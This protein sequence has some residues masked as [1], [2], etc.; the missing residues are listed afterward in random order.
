MKKL[1]FY[2][3]WLVLISILGMGFIG[4]GGG[5]DNNENNTNKTITGYVID[6]PVAGA[7]IEVYDENGTLLTKEENATDENGKYSITIKKEYSKILL[8]AYGGEINNT[9][10]D[11]ELSSICFDDKCNMTPITT[12]LA[13]NFEKNM[14]VITKKDLTNFSKKYLNVNDYKNKDESLNEKIVK[15]CKDNNKKISTLAI[16]ISKN[17]KDLKNNNFLDLF[18]DKNNFTNHQNNINKENNTSKYEKKTNEKEASYVNDSYYNDYSYVDYGNTN[19]KTNTNTNKTITGYVIDD[20]VVGAT[21]EVYDENGTLLTKEENATD[22]N[23]KFSIPISQNK[24]FSPILKLVAYKNNGNNILSAYVNVDKK[25]K[26]YVTQDTTALIDKLILDNKKVVDG[27]FKLKKQYGFV[28]GKITDLNSYEAKKLKYIATQIEHSFKN[29]SQYSAFLDNNLTEKSL[30]IIQGSIFDFSALGYTNLDCND[31]S[32]ININNTKISISSDLN[33]SQTIKCIAKNTDSIVFYNIN[34]VP[35]ATKVKTMPAAKKILSVNNIQ[36]IKPSNDDISI[37]DTQ[38]A[39]IF[40]K[41]N[42]KV[43][44]AENLLSFYPD[45]KVL[46]KPLNLKIPGVENNNSSFYLVNKN[47]TFEKIN[48]NYNNGYYYVSVPHF[49][50]LSYGTEIN[51]NSKNSSNTIDYSKIKENILNDDSKMYI[52][53]NDISYPKILLQKG[54]SETTLK[55]NLNVKDLLALL[56]LKN[57]KGVIDFDGTNISF[58]DGSLKFGVTDKLSNKESQKQQDENLF[59]NMWDK[60]LSNVIELSTKDSIEKLAEKNKNS[61]VLIKSI[62]KTLNDT[63]NKYQKDLNQANDD[64]NKLEKKSLNKELSI[65]KLDL[66]I[67][68][69]QNKYKSINNNFIKNKIQTELTKLFIRAVKRKIKLNIQEKNIIKK[70]FIKSV[71][72]LNKQIKSLK[73]KSGK[74]VAKLIPLKPLQS[75]V[76]TITKMK[77]FTFGPFATFS[78]QLQIDNTTNFF[79]FDGG[80]NLDNVKKALVVAGFVIKSYSIS[81]DYN[82]KQIDDK[83]AFLNKLKN[84]FPEYSSDIQD[85]IDKLIIA[86]KF[87]YP[88]VK[89]LYKYFDNMTES[90][91]NVLDASNDIY[92]L[93]TLSTK[94]SKF[95]E[96]KGFGVVGSGLSIANSFGQVYKTWSAANSMAYMSAT[97]STLAYKISN[98]TKLST[99]EQ[100][101]W[102]S[103]FQTI[104]NTSLVSWYYSDAKISEKGDN[105]MYVVGNA[106][107][108]GL[109][110]ASNPTLL[111]LSDAVIKSVLNEQIVSTV[112]S[113]A[114][115][116]NCFRKESNSEDNLMAQYL[117]KNATYKNLLYYHPKTKKAMTIPINNIMKLPD[118][119]KVLSIFI[120]NKVLA[121]MGVRFDRKDSNLY[122][123][124]LYSHQS[125][126]ASSTWWNFK[127]EKYSISEADKIHSTDPGSY[128]ITGALLDLD[129]KKGDGILNI[130]VGKN[131]NRIEILGWEK[132]TKGAK[133]YIINPPYIDINKLHTTIVTNNRI[134]PIVDNLQKHINFQNSNDKNNISYLQNCGYIII[135][136]T[137]GNNINYLSRDALSKLYLDSY[138]AIKYYNKQQYSVAVLKFK[139]KIYYFVKDY[140]F[141]K[142]KNNFENIPNTTITTND[143]ENILQIKYPISLLKKEVNSNKGVFSATYI[144]DFFPGLYNKI[145]ILRSKICK[146]TTTFNIYDKNGKDITSNYYNDITKSIYINKN[147]N[148]V[149]G[150]VFINIEA[151]KAQTVD[152]NNLYINKVALKDV[153]GVSIT[154]TKDKKNVSIV[155]NSEFLKNNNGI[156]LNYKE[157]ENL[158]NLKS[159]KFCSSYNYPPVAKITTSKTTITKG[160]TVT[161]DGSMSN[162]NEN[163][164]NYIW[165]NGINEI[166]D[167]RDK[168]I[169]KVTPEKTTTYTLKVI[170]DKGSSD[171]TNITI[172]V[173]SPIPTITLD[174]NIQPSTITLLP[175]ETLSDKSITLYV[176]TNAN[177]STC[178]VSINGK[179]VGMIASQ[180]ICV[181]GANGSIIKLD[182]NNEKIGTNTIKI[183]V[184]GSDGKQYSKSISFDITKQTPNYKLSLL[185]ENYKDGTILKVSDQ[186]TISKHW[187]IKN[188]SNHK[189]YLKLEQ[190]T[191]KNCNLNLMTTTDNI[192]EFDLDIGESNTFIHNYEIPTKDG[193][194]ECYYKIKDSKGNYYKIDGSNDIWIKIK[195]QSNPL[196]VN[197][198]FDKEIK[199]G[200]SATMI[201]QINNGNPPY[202]YKIDWGDGQTTNISNSNANSTFSNTYNS[203]GTYTVKVKIT[204]KANKSYS[205]TFNL[206]VSDNVSLITKWSGYIDAVKNTGNNTGDITQNI[207]IKD[208]PYD[209]KT[210]N[211]YSVSYV[212]KSDDKLYYTGYKLPVPQGLISLDHKVRVTFVTKIDTTTGFWNYDRE[213]WLKTNR[214]KYGSVLEDAKDGMNEEGIFIVKDL[215]QGTR[216][217]EAVD[218][219]V[220]LVVD[221]KGISTYA[222]EIDK[223]AITT[224]KYTKGS[225]GNYIYKSI[226]SYPDDTGDYLSQIHLDFKGSG[227]IILAYIQY[228]KNGN[229]KYDKD[230]GLI[231]NTK[232]KV[233]DWRLFGDVDDELMEE[234][235][236]KQIYLNFSNIQKDGNYYYFNI[237]NHKFYVD[238][239]KIEDN[240]YIGTQL[241]LY[242]DSLGF[243]EYSKIT[244]EDKVKITP[245]KNVNDF[246]SGDIS[247]ISLVLSDNDYQIY[248]DLTIIHNNYY[249]YARLA[250]NVPKGEYFYIFYSSS[251]LVTQES[252]KV[253]NLLEAIWNEWIYEKFIIDIKN[254]IVTYLVSNDNIHWEKAELN[255]DLSRYSNSKYL[256]TIGFFGKNRAIEYIKV[257]F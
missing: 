142:E 213:F 253:S 157:D 218:D 214:K 57:G 86:R 141:N 104:S 129:S 137:T 204:D 117:S 178:D 168:S 15:Y 62:N 95:L 254:N 116:I 189:V 10:F 123:T 107:D 167:C 36:I 31:T 238:C 134:N 119:S 222:L 219:F 111:G 71:E 148:K 69:L 212:K 80:K 153:K 83:I 89:Q 61:K 45:G 41:N 232:D 29:N 75:L 74:S 6:D 164:V 234:D 38:D 39:T 11:D 18:E 91:A 150:N 34:L 94:F 196:L 209:N 242:L 223:N 109:S 25:N 23:G 236:N 50:D 124:D 156:E 192:E 201:V 85:L 3:V 226:Y 73:L 40:L 154:I 132:G 5:S 13:K 159:I 115:G 22:E 250:L 63:I 118:G 144:D 19:T 175:N 215:I 133:A 256:K 190:D 252:S 161:L 162:S 165:S 224:Y 47:G 170:D 8:K 207:T 102:Y 229:G 42:N 193:E 195:V 33:N 208:K 12:I 79:G 241:N 66:E 72:R 113:L 90:G 149:F 257:N 93:I 176:T 127:G 43:L 105:W 239:N 231:L 246:P 49:T 191:S 26:I 240:K 255:V 202:S 247:G 227:D 243:K 216:E 53:K 78:H 233:V 56:V 37:K 112:W 211:D 52:Q 251:N 100:L 92:N 245:K 225:D 120:K 20:P 160:E 97:A 146:F 198:D 17:L 158:Q 147:F 235:N 183:T 244:I 163:L 76:N 4:C 199:V 98:N 210:V 221:N 32:K 151:V 16:E 59:F 44:Q 9:K 131:V 114:H 172:N 171:E 103:L 169:C 46:K 145:S 173:K 99:K 197:T 87:D 181:A 125:T 230:E 30:D 67:E 48:S 70:R 138:I 194:Y 220:D 186:D 55:D 68:K 155:F 128:F 140:I 188:T 184:K 65:Q 122:E 108:V 152:I 139:D 110:V 84:Y 228:D 217:D 51:L 200:S 180:S 28:N 177:C 27:Y 2:G 14:T 35:I 237:N 206:K 203:A 106:F 249:G 77:E 64:I 130:I 179:S 96:K 248:D 7:T 21:I 54:Y 166:S 82:F 81:L 187:T 135:D 60:I 143:I 205:K 185:D 88:F 121:R 126:L 174:A 1:K 136:L 101:D 58:N 24:L 182:N